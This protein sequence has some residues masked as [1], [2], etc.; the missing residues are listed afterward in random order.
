[1]PEGNNQHGRLGAEETLI[2]DFKV[3]VEEMG[4]ETVEWI[5]LSEDNVLGRALLN[6]VIIFVFHER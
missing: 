2:L 5:Y 6:E 1:M 4:C 3:G